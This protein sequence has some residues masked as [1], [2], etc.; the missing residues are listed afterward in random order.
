MQYTSIIEF[1]L[2]RRIYSARQ[3]KP[4]EFREYKWNKINIG[5]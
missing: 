2:M 4:A 3:W 1:F 5:C